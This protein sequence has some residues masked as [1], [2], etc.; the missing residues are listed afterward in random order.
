MYYVIG[1]YF[2]TCFMYAVYLWQISESREYNVVSLFAIIFTTLI[3]PA[4]YMK[5]R[6]LVDQLTTHMGHKLDQSETKEQ[7]IAEHRKKSVYINFP[8]GQMVIVKSNEDDDPY[9]VGKVTDHDAIGSSIVPMIKEITTGKTFLCL[10]KIHY[11]SKGKAD[12]LDK[13]TP[14]EQWN[15]MADFAAKD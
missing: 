1:A 2:F 12:A 11:Y 6:W 10:G 9:W 13:L 8:V 15:V 4:T 14:R 3:A 7:I 5:R